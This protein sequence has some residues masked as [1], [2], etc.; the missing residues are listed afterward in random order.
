MNELGE[1]TYRVG[2]FAVG[3]LNESGPFDVGIVVVRRDYVAVV[4][5]GG[6]GGVWAVIDSGILNKQAVCR[7]LLSTEIGGG[8]CVFCRG[9][10]RGDREGNIPIDWNGFDRTSGGSGAGTGGGGDFDWDG[11]WVRFPVW[12]RN[13]IVGVEEWRS[14]CGR[15]RRGGGV[16]TGEKGNKGNG[17]GQD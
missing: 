14:F 6:L 16:L 1:S 3:L 2:N 7:R 12:W 10:I 11:K 13:G 9:F 5:A 4:I 15:E 17:S 8:D